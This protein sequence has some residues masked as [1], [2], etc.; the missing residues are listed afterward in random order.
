MNDADFFPARPDVEPMIYSYEEKNPRYAGMHKVG[1]A[2]A[3]VER[4]VA[5]QFPDSIQRIAKQGEF[6][7][8]SLNEFF[9]AKGRG[10]EA[11]FV[12]EDYVQKWLDLI[13]GSYLETTTDELKLGKGRP[14]IKRYED[15][16]LGYT[17]LASMHEGE[18][19]G[20]YNTILS[21][22]DYAELARQQLNAIGG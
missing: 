2:S 16:S 10:G 8:F 6:D 15:A 3:G 12:H 19:V 14:A 13:R 18:G 17:G 20:L 5:E 21:A 7:E 4:R 22:A 1:F 11:K 9:A